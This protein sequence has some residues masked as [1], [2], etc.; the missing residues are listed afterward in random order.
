M[1]KNSF[2][3]RTLPVL[4]TIASIVFMLVR[5]FQYADILPAR[6]DESL[7][8][9]K[10][11]LFA[12]GTYSPFEPYGLRT[13]KNPLSFLIPG[14]FQSLFGAGL[15]S[16]RIFSILL[17]LLTVIAI[18]LLVKKFT[19]NNWITTF[20]VSA[21]ALNPFY[22]WIFAQFV[23]QSLVAALLAWMLVFT[24]G[25]DKP[26]WQII[27]GTLLSVIIVQVRQNMLPIIPFVILYTYWEEGKKAGR[28]SLIS[29]V[30]TF[31]V[32]T[33][34]YWPGIVRNYFEVIPGTISSLVR[35]FVFLPNLEQPATTYSVQT[36]ERVL[37]FTQGLRTHYVEILG[38]VLT[39]IF[40]FSRP[41]AKI[42]NFKAIIFL[43]ITFSVLFLAHMWAAIF[44]DYCV[45]CFSNYLTFFGIIGTILFSLILF[46]GMDAPFPSFWNILGIISILLICSAAGFSIHQ[47]SGHFLM[48]LTVPRIKNLRIV[49][50]SVEL[51]TLLANKYGL[52][53]DQLE[54]IIPSAFG[55]I[56]G[57]LIVVVAAL[58]RKINRNPVSFLSISFLFVALL[59]S[60]LTFQMTEEQYS[61]T[62]KSCSSNI[63]NTYESIGEYLDSQ[64]EPN[65]K[66]WLW[67]LSGQIILSYIDD[68]QIYPPQLNHMFNYYIGGNSD[69]LYRY[70]Y[71]NE[72]L[73]LTWLEDADYAIVENSTFTGDVVKW[74]NAEQFDE[75]PHTVPI[76]EC[77]PADYF[78][79]FRRK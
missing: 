79:I 2:L 67:S 74:I 45:F 65:S 55:F 44:N 17:G 51:W 37:A 5:S 4:L 64:I 27:V 25:K 13:N 36:I 38:I 52:N 35:N 9:Y 7:Y 46:E 62:L 57:L 54:M 73:A 49:P 75:L 47:D 50:G 58:T 6:L 77:N 34:I 20:A 40:I 30:A 1:R 26:L 53:Y 10:G 28:I 68:I 33:A 19:K 32:M 63:I 29:G 11:L 41:K 69:E 39:N 16:G 3:N 78:R 15:R 24:L 70:G 14:W 31:A 76:N 21:I 71:W 56:I 18:G 61:G 60:P 72:E 12:K 42:K 66:V 43:L 48:E 23:S 22:A 8:L 59:G